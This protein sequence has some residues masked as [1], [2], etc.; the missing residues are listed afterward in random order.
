MVPHLGLRFANAQR[1]KENEQA[2]SGSFGGS[3]VPLMAQSTLLILED[4]K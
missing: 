3:V 2:K 4:W 1:G